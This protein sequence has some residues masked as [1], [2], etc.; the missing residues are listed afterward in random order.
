K[1]ESTPIALKETEFIKAWK[2]AGESSILEL[3]IDGKKENVLIHDIDFDPLKD[4]PIHADFLVVEM[5]KPIK[6]DVKIEFTGESD[7]V[8][9]G[10][11]LVKVMHEIHIEALPKDLPSEIVVDI[12]SIKEM[13]GSIKIEDIKIPSGVTILNSPSVMVVFV[14]A[15]KTEEELKAEEATA[16]GASLETIEVVG[17]KEKE[18]EAAAEAEAEA[19]KKE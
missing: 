12:S 5:N 14:E 9:A 13:G 11:S 17:K 19:E 7:A 2:S 1:K 6:V 3:E 8:K 15:P 10:G 18:A 4:N 16:A